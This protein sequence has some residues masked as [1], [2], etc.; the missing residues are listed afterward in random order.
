[1]VSSPTTPTALAPP[2]SPWARGT[3]YEWIL[4]D[5][6]PPLQTTFVQEVRSWM[7]VEYRPGAHISPQTL[8]SLGFDPFLYQVR[9]HV[10]PTNQSLDLLARRLY[11]LA[12]DDGTCLF[13]AVFYEQLGEL[14]GPEFAWVQLP[15]TKRNNGSVRAW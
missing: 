4:P 14:L 7:G 10:V 12:C 1:M 5:P 2:G 8:S 13:L 15:T 3:G 6:L 11:H 9:G